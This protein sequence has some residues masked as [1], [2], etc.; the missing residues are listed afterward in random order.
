M[1]AAGNYSL[2]AN[3]RNTHGHAADAFSC[4][5]TDAYLVVVK[6]ILAPYIRR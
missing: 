3:R 4:F 2:I 6:Q 1:I 5:I